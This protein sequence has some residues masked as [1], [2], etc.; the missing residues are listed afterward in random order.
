MSWK[1]HSYPRCLLKPSW[2]SELGWWWWR[3]SRQ[4]L[5]DG[6]FCLGGWAP[7][8]GGGTGEEWRG[9]E[10]ASGT[11]DFAA[12]PLTKLWGTA[13]V[14]SIPKTDSKWTSNEY[15]LIIKNMHHDAR[16]NLPPGGLGGRAGWRSALPP[17]PWGGRISKVCELGL[18]PTSNSHWLNSVALKQKQSSSG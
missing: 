3:P 13:P 1:S 15:T 4:S 5:N 2:F 9:F 17:R 6:P 8:L 14:W 10:H 16:R 18:H 12:W 11:L 7:G